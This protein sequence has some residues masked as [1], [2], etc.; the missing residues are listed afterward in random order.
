MAVGERNN[1]VREQALAL[2]R[3]LA[4]E[5]LAADVTDP[6]TARQLATA[7]WRVSP[8]DQAYSS[9]S[10]LLAEQ[11]EDGT[12]YADVSAK[13]NVTGVAFSPDG[14][15]LATAGSDGKVRLWNPATGRRPAPLPASAKT[16]RTGWRSVRTASCWPPPT[17]TARYGCGTRPPASPSAHPCFAGKGTGGG[18]T[19][20]AFSPDG[21]L[22]AT[23]EGD[24]TVRL[25]NPATGQPVG[26]PLA[27]RAGPT[28]TP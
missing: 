19:A 25:W 26:S 11:L 5:S 24:G 7:A 27:A 1:A 22:L 10:S 12:L 13:G 3:Q 14:K 15:L 8:T 2:S 20:V 16:A 4:T 21:K 17:E 28:A 18:V 9:M 6:V 23:A